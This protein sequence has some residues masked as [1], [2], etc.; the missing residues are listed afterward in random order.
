MVESGD[1]ATV[2][3]AIRDTYGFQVSEQF[4]NDF[5]AFVDKAVKGDYAD[6]D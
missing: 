4:A 3:Q 5:I 6:G 1:A 2:Q